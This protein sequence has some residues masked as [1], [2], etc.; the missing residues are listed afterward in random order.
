MQEAL[1]TK[2][3]YERIAKEMDLMFGDRSAFQAIKYLY[4]CGII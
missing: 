2:V 1:E 3:S 4:D